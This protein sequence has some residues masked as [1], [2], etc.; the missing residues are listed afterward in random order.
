M[1]RSHTSQV[2]LPFGCLLFI[3]RLD[4]RMEKVSLTV[5]RSSRVLSLPK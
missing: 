2:K 3:S 4:L 5:L 1:D